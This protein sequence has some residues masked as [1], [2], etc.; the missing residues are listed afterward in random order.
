M[1]AWASHMRRILAQL[2]EDVIWTHGGSPVTVRGV[3]LAPH[4]Q[5][6]LGEM[7][8]VGDEDPMFAVMADDVPGLAGGDTIQRG[9]TTYKVKPSLEPDPVSGVTVMQLEA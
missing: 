9:S 1:V 5:V 6:S 7:V 4:R 3:Y 2:G 8:I